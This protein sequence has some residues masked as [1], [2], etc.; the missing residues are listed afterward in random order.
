MLV[1]PDGDDFENLEEV[2]HTAD[3]VPSDEEVLE[4]NEKFD[5]NTAL[6][7]MRCIL[8]QPR[9]EDDWRRTAICHTYT[10]CG[11]ELHSHH[12]QWQLYQCDL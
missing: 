9:K 2:A 10:K 12:R 7:V 11:D 3:E 1:Q 6:Q 8:T 5:K 4:S